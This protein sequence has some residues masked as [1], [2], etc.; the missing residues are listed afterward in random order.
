MVKMSLKYLDF[1]TQSVNNLLWL[2]GHRWDVCVKVLGQLCEIHTLL[3]VKSLFFLIPPT[4]TSTHFLRSA[5]TNCVQWLLVS[6]LNYFYIQS[7]FQKTG[8]LCKPHIKTNEP[9]LPAVVSQSG[10]EPMYYPLHSHVITEWGPSGG[11]LH[12]SPRR[13]HKFCSKLV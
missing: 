12:S 3:T 8:T 7:Q 9:C 2:A 4:H 11:D 10:P 13:C 6:C 1:Y 5:R